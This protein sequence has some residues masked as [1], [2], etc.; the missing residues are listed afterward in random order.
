VTDDDCPDDG[1]FDGYCDSSVGKMAIMSW[2]GGPEDPVNELGGVDWIRA[3]DWMPY[4]RDTFVTPPFPGYT[5]GH[6]AFSAAAAVVL[7]EFTGNP[8]FPGGMGTF[9]AVKD[10]YLV[11]EQG[12][13]ETITLQWATYADAADEAGLSRRFGGIHPFYD[14]Y[15]SRIQGA[16][17]GQSAWERAQ[18]FYNH[19]VDPGDDEDEDEDDDHPGQGHGPGHGHAYGHDHDEDS[20]HPGHGPGNGQGHGHSHDGDSDE[21]SD[22]GVCPGRGEGGGL[23]QGIQ[24]HEGRSGGLLELLAGAGPAGQ[25]TSG[26]VQEPEEGSGRKKARE[27]RRRSPRPQR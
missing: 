19:G 9:T 15:P 18:E 5:S 6:S 4:Q 7:T 14:D 3:I 1:P 10:E 2:R 21:D 23:S 17:V 13:S 8:F 11:F 22:D 24:A 16:D 26:D 20:D 25:S 12:P 27:I